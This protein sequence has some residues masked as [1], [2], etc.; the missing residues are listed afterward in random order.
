MKYT[1][2]AQY[3]NESFDPNIE[4]ANDKLNALEAKAG[5]SPSPF[6]ANIE[7]V[8][9]LIFDLE[10]AAPTTSIS[11]PAVVASGANLIT[12]RN[13][14]HELINCL[15][16]TVAYQ[17]E[18]KTEA[19]YNAAITRLEGRVKTLTGSTKVPEPP[20]PA[21]GYTPKQAAVDFSTSPK[22]SGLAKAIGAA[23]RK[24]DAK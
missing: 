16:L 6:N 8:N 1:T 14:Y 22:A 23:T 24:A 7:Q 12:L 15:G 19:E 2:Y 11:K 18:C 9:R 10:N 20:T 5:K 13:R 17:A 4:S 3:E 21:R